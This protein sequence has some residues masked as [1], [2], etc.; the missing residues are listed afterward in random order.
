MYIKTAFCIHDGMEIWEQKCCIFR[1]GDYCNGWSLRREGP[2]P[3]GEVVV[4]GS[5][6]VHKGDLTANFRLNFRD[7]FMY[8]DLK[9]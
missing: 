8:E 5:E 1:N 3:N 2:D 6:D 9:E 7:L 4:L